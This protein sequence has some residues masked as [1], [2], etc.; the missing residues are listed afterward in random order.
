M[1]SSGRLIW[2]SMLPSLLIL[3]TTSGCVHGSTPPVVANSFCAI[4]KP[5]YYDSSADSAKT[6]RQIEEHNRKVVCLCEGDCP[7]AQK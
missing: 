1:K 3:T 4:A 5:I 2:R 7:A 6:V